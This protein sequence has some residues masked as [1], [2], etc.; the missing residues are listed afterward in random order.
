MRYTACWIRAAGGKKGRAVTA[1]R[2]GRRIC[3]DIVP[4]NRSMSKDEMRSSGDDASFSHGD[5]STV[6]PG[7]EPNTTWFTK[8]ARRTALV[9]EWIWNSGPNSGG[10]VRGTTWLGEKKL[11]TEGAVNTF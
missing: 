9:V 5:R 8:L 1:W 7:I 11:N 6:V 10:S 2:I 3:A 4:C